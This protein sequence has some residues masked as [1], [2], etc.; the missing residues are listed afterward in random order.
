M[1]CL[2]RWRR[3]GPVRALERTGRRE[4]RG[5]GWHLHQRALKCTPTDLESLGVACSS[6]TSERKASQLQDSELE[7]RASARALG[8]NLAPGTPCAEGGPKRKSN[9]MGSP[10]SISV[11]RL[12]S[13]ESVTE[14]GGTGG[15]EGGDELRLEARSTERPHAH[16]PRTLPGPV[17]RVRYRIRDS[18]GSSSFV[19]V[20][21][22]ERA[23]TAIPALGDDGEGQQIYRFFS[24]KAHDICARTCGFLTM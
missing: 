23:K 11:I 5:G 4:R 21:D 22:R 6:S 9:D 3:A 17:A 20:E 18:G 8:R 12:T 19:V 16:S 14:G 1:V 10:G 7:R 15:W 24:S 13:I 2:T